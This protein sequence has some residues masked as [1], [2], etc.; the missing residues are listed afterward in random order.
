MKTIAI[1]SLLVVT[2]VLFWLVVLPIAALLSPV[3]AFLPSD[4]RPGTGTFL[5]SSR[6]RLSPPPVRLLP[7]WRMVEKKAF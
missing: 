5:R 6:S 2:S 7:G 4:N 3:F 1:E